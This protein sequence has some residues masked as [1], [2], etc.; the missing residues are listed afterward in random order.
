MR[1]LPILV[2]LAVLLATLVA[3]ASAGQSNNPFVG[4]WESYDDFPGGD[5]SHVRLQ[6]GAN[7]HFHLR[8]DAATACLNEGFGFVPGAI[9]GFGEVSNDDR[10]TL[11]TTGDL[12]C[13]TRDGRGRQLLAADFSMSLVY[14]PLTDTLPSDF[15]C[16]Y[17]TGSDPSACD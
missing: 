14:D 3:P 11:G 13:Y 2:I 7:G 4:S 5:F 6:V 16:Y 12:Y 17:R 1:R 9:S 8:D 15:N 10:W